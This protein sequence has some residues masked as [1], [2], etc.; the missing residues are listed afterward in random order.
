[1]GSK[2]AST[3]TAPS[4]SGTS[5]EAIQAQIDALPKI[6]EA[7]KKYGTEFDNQYLAQM[8]TYMPQALETQIEMEKKYAP[9]LFKLAQ[10][11]EATL[12][13]EMATGRKVLNEYLGQQDML[14]PE[15]LRIAKEDLRSSYGA[16]GLG[17]SGMAAEAELLELT[18]LRQ[19][20]KTQR[21][22]TALSVLGL[23]PMNTQTSTQMSASP[24]SGSLV[25]NV[26]P[27]DIFGLTT[28][29][30]AAKVGMYGNQQSANSDLMGGLL[31]MGGQLG[32]SYIKGKMS[33]S[34]TGGNAATSTSLF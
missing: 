17:E 21:L 30:Y 5:A 26:S 32:S 25:K 12:N 23:Q 4:A 9:E 2:S 28:S 1:M 24:A 11:Q 19:S 27:S 15:E 29:N 20:L 18:K 10:E 7:Q 6:L 16:R 31:S 14:T 22:N 3:P 13:P 34:G 33:Q 8:K